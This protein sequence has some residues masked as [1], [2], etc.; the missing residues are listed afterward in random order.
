MS[1]YDMSRDQS[2]PTTRNL[3]FTL[4][5]LLVVIAIISILAAML[6]P[7]L[8]RARET[9]RATSCINN[10]R[11]VNLGVASYADENDGFLPN[12][13]LMD[14]TP[15]LGF[16]D[17]TGKLNDEY[18]LEARL[19]KCPSDDL[20]RLKNSSEVGPARSYAGNDAK[21]CPS[22]YTTPWPQYQADPGKPR[23]AVV[24]N[25]E[26]HRLSEIPNHVF[27]FGEPYLEWYATSATSSRFLM[28]VGN[29]ELSSFDKFPA[30]AHN[31]NAGN[32]AFSDGRA[33]RLTTGQMS[34][35]KKGVAYSGQLDPWKWEE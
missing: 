13:W 9:A 24:M 27:V 3:S 8:Q 20:V 1:R 16:A 17:W 7:A 2:H 28:I 21:F 15:T 29:R 14:G 35:F 12:L 4:I 32:Y 19:F 31:G 25:G 5:E 18:D 30:S 22:G 10:M 34:A 6:L 23:E 26:T 11:Q 33:E